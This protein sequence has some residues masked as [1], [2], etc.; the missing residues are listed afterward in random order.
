MELCGESYLSIKQLREVFLLSGTVRVERSEGTIAHL[1]AG[2]AEGCI[3]AYTCIYAHS[4]W[5]VAQTI[6]CGIDPQNL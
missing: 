4:Y 6:L 5:S 1:L 2:C 3:F